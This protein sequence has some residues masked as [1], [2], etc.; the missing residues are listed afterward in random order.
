[1]KDSVY[2]LVLRELPVQATNIEISVLVSYSSDIGRHNER[3]TRVFPS[4]AEA[5]FKRESDKTAYA[6]KKLEADIH[7]ALALVK[8]LEDRVHK[9]LNKLEKR[10]DS[11][12][13]GT[14]D[15]KPT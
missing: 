9:R 4:K 3:T 1:M 2:E 11:D 5:T 12:T 14:A 8:G 6:V 10:N 7:Q 15:P 13:T